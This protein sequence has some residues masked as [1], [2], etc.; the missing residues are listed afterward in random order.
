[1]KLRAF[2]QVLED[3]VP[4]RVSKH[5]STDAVGLSGG[6]SSQTGCCNSLHTLIASNLR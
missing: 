6:R 5:L 4:N 3:A 1:M 2:R